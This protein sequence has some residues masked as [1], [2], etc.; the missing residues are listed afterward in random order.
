[1]R[2]KGGGTRRN[3]RYHRKHGP[4][5]CSTSMNLVTNVSIMLRVVYYAVISGLVGMRERMINVEM[6]GHE[7][8]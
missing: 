8:A 3:V 5:S 6:D 7:G 2:G 1:M 4:T